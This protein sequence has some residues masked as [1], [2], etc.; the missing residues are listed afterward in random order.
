MST[1]QAFCLAIDAALVL[2]SLAVVAIDAVR[3]AR[4]SAARTAPIPIT[5]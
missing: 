2:S 4:G 5:E 3:D 1:A